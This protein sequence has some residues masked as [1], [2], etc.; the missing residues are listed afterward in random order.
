M[1]LPNF[2]TITR[3]G[4]DEALTLISEQPTYLH[5]AFL[6]KQLSHVALFESVGQGGSAQA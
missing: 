6:P 2:L 4:L 1:T 3:T 5:S